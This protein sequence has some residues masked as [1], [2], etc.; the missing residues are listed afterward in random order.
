MSDFVTSPA[1]ADGAARKHVRPP[2][3]GVLGAQYC[4]E[5]A[6]VMKRTKPSAA[7]IAVAGFGRGD[8]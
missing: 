5:D 1:C 2:S 3:G 8:V 7:V 4:A 6:S